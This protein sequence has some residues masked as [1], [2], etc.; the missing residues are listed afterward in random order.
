LGILVNN[1]GMEQVC[2]SLDIEEDLWD[3]IFDTNLKGA[4]F[5]AQAAARAMNKGAILNICSLTSER[6]IPTAVPYGSSKTGL[7]GMTRALAV[8]WA[9]RGIRVNAVE[10]GYFRTALTEVFY[11]NDAWQQSMLSNI[12]LKRFGELSDLVGA[13]VFLSSDAASYITGACLAID[14]GTLASI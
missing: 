2:P 9:P 1:A 14:G 7:L 4:F 5:V 10:P 12:P 11:Q 3:R 6:G 8:E 13:A